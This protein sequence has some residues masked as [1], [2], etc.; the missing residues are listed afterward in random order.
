LTTAAGGT[1]AGVEAIG[2]GAPET[3]PRGFGCL[4]DGGV[5]VHL[6]RGVLV[7]LPRGVLVHLARGVL[8]D[9]ARGVADD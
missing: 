5:L 7:D 8:V 9:L 1:G 3:A 4:A 6:A 2:S